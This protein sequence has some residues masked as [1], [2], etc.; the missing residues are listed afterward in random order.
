MTLAQAAGQVGW[1]SAFAPGFVWR[2]PLYGIFLQAV[3]FICLSRAF[4][5][6]AGRCWGW[7]LG[8]S[9]WTAA[10]LALDAN[11]FRLADPLW[12]G[13]GRYLPLFAVV[14]GGLVAGWAV[15]LLIALG[16]AVHAARHGLSFRYH[17]PLPYWL[18]GFGLLALGQGFYLTGLNPLPGQ[19]LHLA[20]VL[21][22]AYV[23]STQRL[24][25]FRHSLRRTTTSLLVTILAILLYTLVFL[26][27][28]AVLRF[29]DGFSPLLGGLVVAGLLALVCNPLLN[30]AQQWITA[31][32][33]GSRQDVAQALRQYSQS[34]TNILDLQLLATVAIATTSEVLD[35]RRGFLML[36]DYEKGGD[37]LNFFRLRGV[38]GMGHTNPTPGVLPEESPLARFL[39]Y[40]H[41]PITQAEIDV[42]PLFRAVTVDERAWLSSLAVEV[43]VPI[44]SKNEWIGLLA[45]GPKASGAP[46]SPENLDLLSTLADQTAVALENTRLVEGLMRLNNDFRRAYAAMDQAHRHLERLDRTKTDFISIA[47]HE[48]RTPLTIISASSQMLLD[49]P[50]LAENPYYKQMLNKIYTG[51][52]RLH[53]IVDSLLDMAK[54]DTRALQLDPQPVAVA[55]MIRSVCVDLRKAFTERKQNLVIEKLDDLPPVRADVDALHKVFHHLIIN[56]IK[57]TPDNGTIT[58]SGGLSS[59]TLQGVAREALEI[60]IRDTGIGIDPRFHDLIFVKFYQTGELALHSSG[61][62]KFKGGGPGL[63]LAIVRG[64]VE[65]HGGKVW[66]ESPGYDEEKC[67][68][69]KFHVLLPTGGPLKERTSQPVAPVLERQI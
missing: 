8:G 63:G 40:E 60:V 2:L 65:S 58:I 12:S 6:Q 53:E 28:Q 52:T 59:Q 54:I 24:P 10:M 17:S 7:L 23:V 45:V 31:R 67:P 32:I 64:I 57:Y 30:R 68:G 44:Y 14:T 61:K 35:V 66:V 50:S 49:E 62:T 27:V 13:G 34:I 20:G 19:I 16:Q 33:S 38:K 69:S 39:R 55:S 11:F 18:V 4:L 21:L 47:S 22:I 37:G 9:L 29:Q 46:F 41:K 51:T 15:V 25:D 48:L 43:L 3:A 56:A 36:V 42:Q 1:L 26:A 5:A